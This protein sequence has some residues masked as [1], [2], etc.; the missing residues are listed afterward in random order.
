MPNIFRTG[1]PTNFKLGTQTEHEDPHQRQAPWPPRSKDKVTWPGV[2]GDKPR[3]KRPRNTQ[4]GGKVV[5]ST[6]NK[7]NQFQGQRSRSPG[8]LMQRLEVRL[9]FRMEL[10]I[11]TKYE[12]RYWEVSEKIGVKDFSLGAIS[13]SL[14]EGCRKEKLWCIWE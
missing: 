10:Q 3:K 1:R 7:V 14:G 9:I 4:I 6:G 5:H 13:P 11:W 8:R 2:L 12:V